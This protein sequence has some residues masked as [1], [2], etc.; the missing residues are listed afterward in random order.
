MAFDWNGYLSLAKELQSETAGQVASTEIEAKQ[1]SGV[2]RA[3]YSVYHIAE[4]YAIA[5]FGYAP[6]KNE[7]GN[8]FHANLREEYRKRFSN[9]DHQ[10]IRQ[11]LFRLHKARKECDYDSDVKNTP[12]LLQSAIIDA[13][14]IVTILAN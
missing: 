9:V 7:G 10:E 11:I 5:N 13:D 8:Q 1:R 14:R 3:Y 6:K 12:S 4:D 2:S